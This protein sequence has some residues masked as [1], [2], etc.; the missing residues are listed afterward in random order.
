MDVEPEVTTET[1]QPLTTPVEA[2]P[3][4]APVVESP[5]MT[6]V[7]SVE[8]KKGLPKWAKIVGIVGVVIVVLVA[9]ILFIVNLATA[10]PQ[11][12]SQEFLTDIKNNNATEAYTLTS[13]EFQS[14]TSE[15]DFEA[16][17]IRNSVLPLDSGKLASKEVNSDATGS[18]AKFVTVVTKDGVKYNVETQLVKSGDQWK[19]SYL[20]IATQ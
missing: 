13:S 18:N 11:K 15:S 6:P 2:A 8:P 14:A 3:V 19:V 1:E 9:V 17:V 7:S 16:Y 10:A 4:E 20:H 12:V 5:Q